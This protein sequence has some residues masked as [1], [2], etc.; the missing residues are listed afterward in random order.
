MLKH[1][2]VKLSFRFKEEESSQTFKFQSRHRK[3][4]QRRKYKSVP[5]PS[6][7]KEFSAFSYMAAVQ[8][9]SWFVPC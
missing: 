7:P 2:N 3:S 4:Y 8:S 1:I 5:I 9:W 6:G